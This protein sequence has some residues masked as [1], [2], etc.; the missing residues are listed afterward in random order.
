MSTPFARVLSLSITLVAAAFVGCDQKPAPAPSGGNAGAS[1]S[2]APAKHDD[3]AH[4][5]GHDHHDD[6]GPATALGEQSVGGFTVKASRDGALTPGGDA[7]I[8]IWVTTGK[9]ATLRAWIGTDDAKGSM[10][11]KLDIEKDAYHGHVEIPKPLP[12]GSRLHVELE[13]DKGE[14]PRLSFD[15]K[16]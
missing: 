2:S 15:L 9:P 12:A 7:P 5:D 1:G 6:H 10:K 4:G 14:V 8:D 16:A 3:H 13:N 11:A